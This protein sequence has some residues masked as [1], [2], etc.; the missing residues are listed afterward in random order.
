M[1]MT[2]KKKEK[3]DH[4]IVKRKENENLYLLHNLYVPY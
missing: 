2:K 1:M 3:R 4:Q